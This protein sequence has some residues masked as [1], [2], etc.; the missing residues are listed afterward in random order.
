MTKLG[1]AEEKWAFIDIYSP[2]FRHINQSG[3]RS[4]VM[5]VN[6]PYLGLI[7]Y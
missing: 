1:V 4:S 7:G 6:T 5:W 2:L 3:F